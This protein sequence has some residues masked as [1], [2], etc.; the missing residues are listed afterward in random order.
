MLRRLAQQRMTLSDIERPF[1]ALRAIYALAQLVFHLNVHV[2]QSRSRT[3]VLT[4]TLRSRSSVDSSLTCLS[5]ILDARPVRQCILGEE[6]QIES[7]SLPAHVKRPDG[8]TI[9]P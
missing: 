3:D 2:S 7:I 4:R 5:I 1:H 6:R 9:Y 8:S